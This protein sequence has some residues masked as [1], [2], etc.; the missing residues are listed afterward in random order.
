MHSL[1]TATLAKAIKIVM[2]FAILSTLGTA[3]ALAP[4]LGTP[5]TGWRSGRPSTRLYHAGGH[6]ELIDGYT[7]GTMQLLREAPSLDY[8]K[9]LELHAGE[10]VSGVYALFESDDCV[11]VGM[12]N[13]AVTAL[14]EVRKTLGA[15]VSL[16]IEEHDGD[17]VMS[18]VFG[19]WLD[20]ASPGGVRPR[21]NAERAAAR[22]AARGF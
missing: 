14:Q 16:K 18:L 15:D 10:A 20:E 3:S 9:W 8:Q 4:R 22:A 7:G 1:S 2:R 17:G 6:G 5:A 11:F 19:S 12:G 21:V 13:D